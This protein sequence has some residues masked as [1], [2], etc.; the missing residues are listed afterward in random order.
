MVPHIRIEQELTRIMDDDHTDEPEILCAVTAVPDT[1]K[2]ER[3]I[4]LHKPMTKPIST[5]LNELQQA[6]LPNL[7]IP[8][9]ESFLC[10]ENI[11]LL[12]TGKLDLKAVKDKAMQHFAS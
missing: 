5:V 6:G 3:L 12:G 7:W 10:V 9:A 8:S 1:K 4:V 2:G 11:P